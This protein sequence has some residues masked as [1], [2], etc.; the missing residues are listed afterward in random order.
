MLVIG[1]PAAY[2]RFPDSD[3]RAVEADIPEW[4]RLH[5]HVR[6]LRLDQDYGPASKLVAGLQFAQAEAD[7]TSVVVV[8]VDDDIVY[9]PGMLDTLVQRARGNPGCALGYRGFTLAGDGEDQRAITPSRLMQDVQV[10]EGFSMVL[11][12]CAC[13]HPLNDFKAY[14]RQCGACLECFTSDDLTISTYLEKQGIRRI[15]V[16][17][18]VTAALFNLQCITPLGLGQ[19]ALHLGA[20]GA[21]TTNIAK[22]YSVALRQIQAANSCAGQEEGSRAE[23]GL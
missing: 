19:D 23:E 16:D 6:V 11:Y 15:S 18:R 10:L 13:F 9:L 5:P 21:V 22:R 8:T 17:P 12:P 4:V 7:D 20:G 14:L 3:V 1:I 2:P